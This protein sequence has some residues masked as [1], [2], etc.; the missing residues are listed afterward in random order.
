MLHGGRAGVQKGLGEVGPEWS[1]HYIPSG[2][3]GRWRE[4]SRGDPVLL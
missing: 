4:V 2:R 3:R 1:L